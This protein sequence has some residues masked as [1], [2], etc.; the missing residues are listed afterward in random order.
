MS[1]FNLEV[2]VSLVRNPTAGDPS[3]IAYPSLE[4]SE[5]QEDKPR[6]SQKVWAI[7]KHT[8][9]CLVQFFRIQRWR[10]TA[11]VVGALL[12]EP[13]SCF[14]SAYDQ[15]C[16]AQKKYHE[17]EVNPKSL[18]SKELNKK[19]VLLL[20]GKNGNQGMLRY[21]AWRLQND[22][23]I[24]PVFTVNL[25]EGE[26]TM[27]DR[28]IV[29]QKFAEIRSLYGSHPLPIDLVGYSRGA[30]FAHYMGLPQGTWHIKEGGYCYKDQEWSSWRP[31]VG[32]IIRLGS[33]TL[34]EEWEALTQEMQNQVH[35]VRGKYDVLMPETSLASHQHTVETGHVGLPYSDEACDIIIH[36]LKA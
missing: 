11:L 16:G 12:L 32:K 24:G 17:F 21:L 18:S 6:V 35:E 23:D 36:T 28:D 20:H 33:M 29:E 8:I 3:Q 1:P 31:E 25:S 19:P 5:V 13:L 7:Y 27:K 15:R 9:H 10:F 2:D 4:F 26:L 30:E 34:P 14:R 22:P